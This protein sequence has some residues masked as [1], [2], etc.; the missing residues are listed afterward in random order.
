MRKE[1]KLNKNKGCLEGCNFEYSGLNNLE[2]PFNF[3]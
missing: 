1:N 3:R 2:N